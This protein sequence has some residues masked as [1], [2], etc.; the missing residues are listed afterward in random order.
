M[1]ERERERARCPLGPRKAQPASRLSLR[2]PPNLGACA[3][4]W[5]LCGAWGRLAVVKACKWVDEVTLDAP[6]QTTL[7]TLDKFNIDFAVHGEDISVNSD[8]T[9]SYEE[10]KKAGRFKY[11]PRAFPGLCPVPTT[12]YVHTHHR[13]CTLWLSITPWPLLFLL[14]SS[15]SSSLHLPPRPPS[16]SC[17][18]PLSLGRVCVSCAVVSPRAD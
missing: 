3:C 2:V 10:V 7:A 4:P 14:F 11:V 12:K 15:S 1:H 18:T 6:Y 9:D 16:P 5:S 8:G 13:T 17:S